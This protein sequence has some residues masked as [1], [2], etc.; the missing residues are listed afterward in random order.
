MSDHHFMVK[1]ITMINI[2]RKFMAIISIQD[3]ILWAQKRFTSKYCLQIMKM[4][5]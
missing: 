4:S 5:S 3:G 1:S 2:Q